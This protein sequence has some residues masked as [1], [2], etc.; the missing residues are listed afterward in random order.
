MPITVNIPLTLAFPIFA[1]ELTVTFDNVVFPVTLSV[2]VIFAFALA[3]KFNNVTF[4]VTL[5]FPPTYKSLLN[6]ASEFRK[7]RLPPLISINPC[8]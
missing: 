1:L 7:I 3:D 5:T 4:L 2:P 6:D 8:T